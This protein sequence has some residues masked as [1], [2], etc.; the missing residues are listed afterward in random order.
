MASV[1]RG[2]EVFSAPDDLRRH[3][4][5]SGG[6][7]PGRLLLDTIADRHA[8]ERLEPLSLDFK[9]GTSLDLWVYLGPE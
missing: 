3:T 9:D 1:M 2:L 6:L 5:P 7:E 4:P 8:W